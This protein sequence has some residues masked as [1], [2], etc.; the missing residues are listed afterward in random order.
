MAFE[1]PDLPRRAALRVFGAAPLLP[2]LLTEQAR[3][4]RANLLLKQE[5]PSPVAETSVVEPHDR[6]REFL[7]HQPEARAEGMTYDADLAALKSVSPAMKSWIQKCRRNERESV[8][9]KITGRTWY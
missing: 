2:A 1:P 4:T 5:E 7:F 9:R 6:L 3:T 8:W